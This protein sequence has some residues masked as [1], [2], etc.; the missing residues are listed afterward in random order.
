MANK[1]SRIFMGFMAGLFLVTASAT[2]IAVIWDSVSNKNNDQ[3]KEN[4]VNPNQLQGTKLANFTPLTTP[5]DKIQATDVKP[6]T[7]EEVKPNATITFH[8]TG[9]LAADGTIFQSSHDG[10]NQ[11]VTYPLKDLIKGWQ[12]GI[13]GM[14][15]GGTR[16]LII[17]YAQGYG[18]AG[19]PQG[20]IPPKADLVFDIEVTAVKNP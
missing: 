10:P 1:A 3:T 14:K 12:E 13:P 9:A 15:A 4:K 16:R 20:G 18:E 17:P 7:G 5:V 19:S 8:Y 6:G 2:T 11:A